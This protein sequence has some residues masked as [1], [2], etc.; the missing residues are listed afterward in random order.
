MKADIK[1]VFGVLLILAEFGLFVLVIGFAGGV[2]QNL[3]TIGEGMKGI[4]IAVGVMLVIGFV[5]SRIA[6]DE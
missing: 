4:G 5:I 1:D 2:D 3:I 6:K